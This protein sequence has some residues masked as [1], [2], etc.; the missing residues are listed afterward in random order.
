MC[1]QGTARFEGN[2]AAVQATHAGSEMI[3]GRDSAAL[4]T[5]AATISAVSQMWLIRCFFPR[6]PHR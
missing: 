5:L 2:R 6:I 1:A 4:G 3:R